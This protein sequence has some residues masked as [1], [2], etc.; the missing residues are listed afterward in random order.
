MQYVFKLVANL[1]WLAPL[2]LRWTYG[3]P[4]VHT[5]E[6]PVS[7]TVRYRS[8]CVFPGSMKQTAASRSG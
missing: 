2:V 4:Y 8:S 3:P 1:H 5:P 7:H 6:T